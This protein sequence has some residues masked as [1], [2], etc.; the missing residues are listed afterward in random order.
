MISRNWQ[1]KRNQMSVEDK[2]FTSV[3]ES[4][5][6]LRNGHYYLPL[7]FKDSNVTMP[8]NYQQ[9]QQRV[10][11]LKR[12]LE[13][14]EQY[15]KEYAT[16]LEAVIEKGHAEVVPRDE[17][18]TQSGKRWY[19]PH[20]GVHHPKKGSLRVVFD[21]SASFQGTSLNNKLIQGPNQIGRAHV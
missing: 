14:N 11:S 13:K 10:M 9:A 3:M 2:R 20:H 16:F 21:C 1:L 7:P 4:S 8:N 17:L 12:K 18:E 5:K 15:H 19:I 6:E